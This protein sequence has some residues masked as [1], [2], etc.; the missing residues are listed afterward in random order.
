[1]QKKPHVLITNDDG[2]DA[3][4]IKYLW[5]ALVKDFTISIVAPTTEKSGSGLAITLRD[6]LHIQ[7]VPWEKGTHAWRVSG[8]PADCIRM[9]MRVLLDSPPDLIVSGINR[10]SNAGRNV[11]YSG[12][13]GGVIEGVLR[14]VPGIAF[15][16]D[17]YDHP[18]YATAEKHVLP[19][20]RY[21]LDHPLPRGTLLNV[22]VPTSPKILG[23]KLASQGRSYW[24]ENPDERVHP[25]GRP[26]YWLGG[27]WEDHQEET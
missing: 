5:Q 26:Y 7:E 25:E 10:G 11:L 3:I 15:S 24:I 14:N 20:V 22:N 4:G 12:T 21:M 18:D 9:G 1:M 6:P 2:I 16:C 23:V 27:K 19:I 13:V 8:T 17:N